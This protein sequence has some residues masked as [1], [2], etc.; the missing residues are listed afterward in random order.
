MWE[1]RLDKRYG[2]AEMV[3]AALKTKLAN[4]PE[5]SAKDSQRHYDLADIFAEIESAKEDKTYASL[6]SYYDTSSGIKPIVNKLP[7]QLQEKWTSRAISYKKKY[8]VPFP[9]FSMFFFRFC[10]WHE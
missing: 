4:F 8:G 5:F 1:E 6:L 7:A 10:A 3:L 9:P 2:C